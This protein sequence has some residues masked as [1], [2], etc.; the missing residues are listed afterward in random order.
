MIELNKQITGTPQDS[1]ITTTHWF[2]LNEIKAKTSQLRS[3]MVLEC[4]EDYL[5]IID[6]NNTLKQAIPLSSI[7]SN[8]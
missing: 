3:P 8:L 6:T 7:K 1:D 4:V 2:T 5:A